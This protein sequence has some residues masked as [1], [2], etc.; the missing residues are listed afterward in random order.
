MQ[1]LRGVGIGQGV[2]QGPIALMA[3]RLEPPRDE[4]STR[5][6]DEE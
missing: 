6:A 4:K 2:A 1:E 5:D 3:A